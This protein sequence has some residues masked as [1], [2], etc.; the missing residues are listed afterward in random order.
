MTLLHGRE[1]VPDP[2]KDLTL[3]LKA[4]VSEIRVSRISDQVLTVRRWCLG[5]AVRRVKRFTLKEPYVSVDKKIVPQN[6]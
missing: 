2:I 4:P 5:Q 3:S 1:K 6:R